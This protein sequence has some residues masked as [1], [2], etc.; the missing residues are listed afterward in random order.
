MPTCAFYQTARYD[1]DSRTIRA[2]RQRN[3]QT[4]EVP[5]CSHRHS[6]APHRRTAMVS[7]AHVLRCNGDFASCQVPPDKFPD[8]G[9]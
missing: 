5:W 4:V 3:V 1:L 8:T 6:P 7:A 2:D 9:P